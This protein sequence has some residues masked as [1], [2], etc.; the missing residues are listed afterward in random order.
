MGLIISIVLLQM[1]I[2]PLS[3][4][5]G[6]LLEIERAELETRAKK[7][8]EAGEE[9]PEIPP[10]FPPAKVRHEIR[11]EM[12]FLMPPLLLGGISVL[13][14]LYVPAVRNLWNWASTVDWLNSGL[15]SLLGGLVGG[16]VIWLTRI[17]GSY[18]LGKE[19]MGLGDVHLVFGIGA[20]LG[21]GGATVTFFLAPFA[22]IITGIYLVIAHSRR[23][24]PLGPYLSLAAAFVMLFYAPIA[25]YLQPSLIVL[26]AVLR[27]ALLG[28]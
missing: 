3:F 2:L 1:K 7:A 6:D 9:V 8:E 10:E 20:V 18:A 26:I 21:A 28:N 19:A 16:F 22:A 11:K 12:L 23:Q 5:E 4:P 27:Q 25:A 13:L 14:H 17:L 24:L 15:G